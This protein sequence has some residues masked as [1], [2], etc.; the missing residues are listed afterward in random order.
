M[1]LKLILKYF[2][3]SSRA[4]IVV[5]DF[6]QVH[7]YIRELAIFSKLAKRNFEFQEEG[8]GL[9]IYIYIERER[10]RDQ[11]NGMV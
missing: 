4:S 11:W 2:T 10:E 7:R 3:S 5:V 8:R 9:Y 1:P 6:E